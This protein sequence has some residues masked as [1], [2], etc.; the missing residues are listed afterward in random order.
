M[1]MA[2]IFKNTQHSKQGLM[3]RINTYKSAGNERALADLQE[4]T[5]AKQSLMQTW[6]IH[7]ILWK[8]V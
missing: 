3:H 6:E 4:I 8:C 1:H 7:T 5:L 2:D